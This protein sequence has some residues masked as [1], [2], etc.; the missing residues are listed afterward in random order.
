MVRRATRTGPANKEAFPQAPSSEYEP[1]LPILSR[2]EIIEYGFLFDLWQRLFV[3]EM[4]GTILEE[5]FEV[6]H[7]TSEIPLWTRCCGGEVLHEPGLRG[8]KLKVTLNQG[9]GETPHVTRFGAIRKRQARPQHIAFGLHNDYFLRPHT[10]TETHNNT[11]TH[12][13]RR[14]RAQLC[15]RPLHACWMSPSIQGGHGMQTTAMS[16]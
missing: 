7:W 15:S 16:R 13:H 6:Q 1:S 5:A 9:P 4:E 11:H 14:G 3:F 2:R 12:P 10:Y 8:R